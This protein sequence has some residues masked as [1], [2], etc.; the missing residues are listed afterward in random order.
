L[1]GFVTREANANIA[2]HAQRFLD[3]FHTTIVQEVRDAIASNDVVVV[4]M[5]SNPSVKRVRQ[6]LNTAGI[7]YAYLAYGG[8]LSKWK[9]R[10]AIKLWSGWPTYPQ[11]FVK[12][13]L[14]GG[15][16]RTREALADGSFQAALRG[17]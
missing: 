5:A 14:M 6:A 3:G 10:L 11:V 1:D 8:Y 9:E 4:G 16:D 12:G 17:D 7:E 15:K 13:Q 2:P